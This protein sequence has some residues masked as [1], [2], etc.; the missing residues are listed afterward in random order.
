M[1]PLC[2]WHDSSWPWGA[3]RHQGRLCALCYWWQFSLVQTFM[4]SYPRL[5]WLSKTF[6]HYLVTGGCTHH[7]HSAFSHHF[8]FQYFLADRIN[9]STNNLT[10]GIK[11]LVSTKLL[12]FLKVFEVWHFNNKNKKKVIIEITGYRNS[13]GVNVGGL[14]WGCELLLLCQAEILWV[15]YIYPKFRG[16]KKC[17]PQNCF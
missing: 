7:W 2:L 13:L 1:T 11:L 3:G 9:T 17:I 14:L 15:K 16:N 6:W 4:L 12:L 8:F 10:A 5:G